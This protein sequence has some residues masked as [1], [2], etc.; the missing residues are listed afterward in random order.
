MKIGH[1]ENYFS[2]ERRDESDPYAS[3]SISARCGYGD[4]IFVGSNGA[5][6]FDQTEEARQS[7]ADFAALS[8]NETRIN[9]TEGCYLALIRQS[10]GD[11]DVE[12]QIRRYRFDAALKGRVTVA[13]EDSTGFLHELGEMAFGVKP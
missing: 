12:F 1:D 11:I 10:R 3:F 13:G 6:L 9:L 8:R 7:F 5:V 4:S 2:I